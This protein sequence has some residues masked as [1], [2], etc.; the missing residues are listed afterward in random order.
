MRPSPDLSMTLDMEPKIALTAEEELACDLLFEE[1]FG[2]DMPVEQP[3]ALSL[4]A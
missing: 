1:L 4:A 2:E 3:P